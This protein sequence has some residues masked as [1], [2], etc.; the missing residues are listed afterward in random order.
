MA[1][2]AA[3]DVET[4]LPCPACQQH[5]HIARTC[6]EAYMYCPACSG[7]YA[8]RDFVARADEAMEE[9]LENLYV[10]RI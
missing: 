4:T 7:R 1:Y 5:L 6:H 10:N 8:L 9:F 3:R 2:F